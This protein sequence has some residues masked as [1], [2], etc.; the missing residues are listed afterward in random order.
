MKK[1]IKKLSLLFI[2]LLAL[3]LSSCASTLIPSRIN[4]DISKNED[5]RKYKKI[6]IVADNAK[7]EDNTITENAFEQIFISKKL[8]A[9][10]SNKLFPVE[11][12][13]SEEEKNNIIA[14]NNIDLLLYITYIDVDTVTTYIPQRVE[15]YQTPIFNGTTTTY[16]T[17]T[18]I[19][20]GYYET[21]YISYSIITLS[22]AKSRNRI[23]TFNCQ[24]DASYKGALE[25][26]SKSLGNKAAIQFKLLGNKQLFN[27]IKNIVDPSENLSYKQSE[28]ENTEKI[29]CSLKNTELYTAIIS[30]NEVTITSD[31]FKSSM[32]YNRSVVSLVQQNATNVY[33]I[34]CKNETQVE[35]AAQAL[36]LIC[37][38]Y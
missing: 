23:A 31:K 33:Q 8:D 35:P 22:D 13:L 12:K 10:A 24:T 37:N 6:L 5:L 3:T 29:V 34:K 26:V 19:I 1:F 18:R 14:A 32:P 38:K 11:Q 15:T 16:I 7:A 4:A 28:V 36:K 25:T 20:P 2:T 9:V 30:E 17:Q 27:S 21:T